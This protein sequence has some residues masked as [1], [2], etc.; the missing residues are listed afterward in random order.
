MKNNIL[1][2]LLLKTY[3]ITIKYFSYERFTALQI[4]FNKRLCLLF[5]FSAK[6]TDKTHR[7]PPK[8]MPPP[9][10]K[11]PKKN[12]LKKP[13]INNSVYSSHLSYT[14]KKVNL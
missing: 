3:F 13:L 2:K 8:T 1:D 11:R 7:K 14:S 12:A 6:P 4:D 10:I 5:D 9:F